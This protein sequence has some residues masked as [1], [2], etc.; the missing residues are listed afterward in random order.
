MSSVSWP[1]GRSSR[2]AGG[3]GADASACA[4]GKYRRNVVP[5]PISL[6]T[7][8]KPPLRF[9]VP[10]TIDRPRPVPLP[11]SFVVKNG[12]NMRACVLS[13]MPWPVSATD[14]TAYSPGGIGTCGGPADLLDVG[15]RDRLRLQLTERELRVARD[16][17]QR[18]VQI[19]RDAAGE[20]PDRFHLLRLPQLILEQPPLGDVLHRAHH[21][22]RASAR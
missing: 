4:A 3:S 7:K 2:G 9:N 1:R 18:V 6:S 22:R 17:R 8:M 13:V 19:V 20:P 10:Y 12:S 11:I 16:R 15:A 5:R 21:A 14:R